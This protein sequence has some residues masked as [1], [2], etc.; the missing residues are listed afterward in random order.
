[1]W[2]FSYSNT[3]KTSYN[4]A[5]AECQYWAWL[6]I[7]LISVEQGYCNKVL[8]RLGQPCRPGSISYGRENMV[9]KSLLLLLPLLILL[10]QLLLLLLL[11]GIIILIIMVL[12]KVF[13]T[14]RLPPWILKMSLIDVFQYKYRESFK[15][16][17]ASL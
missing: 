9:V 15:L 6:S 2:W 4:Q 10:L 5:K 16:A 13:I 11:L 3:S 7:G 12:I 14:L 17:M 8:I 1:M